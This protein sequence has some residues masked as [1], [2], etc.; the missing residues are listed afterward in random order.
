[1]ATTS[2]PGSFRGWKKRDP[3]TRLPMFA[4]TAFI[5]SINSW[6]FTIEHFLFVISRK[7][8]WESHRWKWWTES[9]RVFLNFKS[10]SWTRL[11]FLYTGNR[12]K[13][14]THFVLNLYNKTIACYYSMLINSVV[15]WTSRKP[16]FNKDD[17]ILFVLHWPLGC[18]LPFYRRL[19]LS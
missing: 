1:M 4:S 18:C 13:A 3:G 10:I 17:Q 11:H 7:N 5:S 9:E 16:S 15:S 14:G 2:P 6:D 19:K 12:V 8:T